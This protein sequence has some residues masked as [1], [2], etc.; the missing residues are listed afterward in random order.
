M[1][2]PPPVDLHLHLLPNVD[3]GP[4]RIDECEAMLRF[5]ALLGAKRLAATPH[6]HG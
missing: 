6:L 3:D 5:F 1:L 2:N 4:S